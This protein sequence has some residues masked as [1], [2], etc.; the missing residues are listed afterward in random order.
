MAQ[1][2]I[3]WTTL[4]WNPIKAFLYDPQT[5]SWSS[6]GNLVVVPARDRIVPPASAAVLASLLPQATRLTPPL[7]HIGMIAGS[8]AKAAV[9]RPLAEWLRQYGGGAAK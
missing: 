8:G 3:Q 9:W 7:G 2:S 1:T 5:D 6:A 4:S